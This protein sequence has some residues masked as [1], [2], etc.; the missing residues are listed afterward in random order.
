MSDRKSFVFSAEASKRL[1]RLRVICRQGTGSDVV[2]LALMVLEDN[3]RFADEGLIQIQDKS[4]NPVRMYHPLLQSE[5]V[6][7]ALSSS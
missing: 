5:P 4:G 7:H 6:E 1:E 2:R 3:V